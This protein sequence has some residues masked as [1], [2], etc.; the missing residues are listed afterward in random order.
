MAQET[1][2]ARFLAAARVPAAVR[3]AALV[4]D[5]DD[6]V[7]W[8]GYESASGERRGRVAQPCRVSES[9]VCTLHVVEEEG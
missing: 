6:R 8:V 1:T 9:T 3:A 5:V 4:L 7:A 2:V